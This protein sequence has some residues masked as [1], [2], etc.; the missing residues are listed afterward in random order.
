MGLGE[1][2]NFRIGW[3]SVF[4]A[5]HT[6]HVSLSLSFGVGF[7]GDRV[8]CCHWNSVNEGARGISQPRV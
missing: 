4:S 3:G 2:P 7:L 8:E 5:S 1:S 6:V